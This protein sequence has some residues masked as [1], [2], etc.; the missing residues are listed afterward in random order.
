MDDEGCHCAQKELAGNLLVISVSI[1]S[2]KVSS[3]SLKQ[4][5]YTSIIVQTKLWVEG[6]PPQ[7]FNHWSAGLLILKNS[8]RRTPLLDWPISPNI[9]NQVQYILQVPLQGILQGMPQMA[10]GV[11]QIPQ[12]S[13]IRQTPQVGRG[14][15]LP[16]SLNGSTSPRAVQTTSPRNVQTSSPRTVQT[17]P[18]PHINAVN[19]ALASPRSA[20]GTAINFMAAC[21]SGLSRPQKRSRCEPDVAQVN[22]VAQNSWAKTVSAHDA[23]SLQTRLLS[24]FNN[25][26]H[27]LL[28]VMQ[29]REE[30]ILAAEQHKQIKIFPL[31]NRMR[32]VHKLHALYGFPATT[33]KELAVAF[34]SHESVAF[35]ASESI[36]ND[37][38]QSITI[39]GFS[40]N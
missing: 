2:S 38:V 13:Q 16:V 27:A 25:H 35:L 7:T 29:Y 5:T 8:K 39:L 28:P 6:D 33:E 37:N 14:P 1:G 18:Q 34:L 30:Q 20:A 11:P 4:P 32:A 10:Q 24:G 36:Y 26:F 40:L 3:V 15:I 22:L 23:A 9:R 31:G 17:A 12:T 19:P 21:A